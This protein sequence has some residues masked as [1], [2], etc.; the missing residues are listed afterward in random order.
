MVGH[1]WSH[2]RM[3]GLKVQ[4][5]NVTLR[6]LCHEQ[7]TWDIGIRCCCI[8]SGCGV[9]LWTGLGGTPC[10]LCNINLPAAIYDIIRR[11]YRPLFSVVANIRCCRMGSMGLGN[12]ADPVGVPAIYMSAEMLIWLS[13]ICNCDSL[14]A[15]WE[16][17]EAHSGTAKHNN[18]LLQP[19]DVW[20]T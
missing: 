1:D 16:G 3:I 4:H 10:W 6:R 9:I 20:Q 15:L 14:D 18:K 19:I 17:V 5:R 11:D 8:D 13:S 7:P 2:A 12:M